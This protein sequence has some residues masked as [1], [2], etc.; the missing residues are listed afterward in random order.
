MSA[1]PLEKILQCCPRVTPE[2]FCETQPCVDITV[3]PAHFI[4]NQPT[5]TLIVYFLA[6]L[7]IIGGIL[8]LRRRGGQV[9]RAW[10]GAA[11]LLAGA[12][13]FTAGTSY[14]AFGYE[15]KCAGREFCL[16]TSWWEVAYL[17]LQ[18]AAMDAILIAVAVSYTLPPWRK[19][20]TWYAVLNATAHFAITAAGAA[21]PV[22][23]MI[24]YEMLMLFSVPNL[25]IFF[26]LCGCSYAKRRLPMDRALMRAG[27]WL[28]LTTAVYYIYFMLGV[29]QFLWARGVW[30]SDNDVL[31]LFMIAWAVYVPVAVVKTVRDAG[32]IESMT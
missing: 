25:I 2:T 28:V 7:Y 4:L 20:L 19:I 23:F 6:L 26:I 27:V 17:V 18:A 30:F 11:M 24:S 16:W 22:K 29:T 13:A 14:Q 21:I 5:S 15:L 3:G 32:A 31:H 10:W 1:G 9:S 8:I 12:A